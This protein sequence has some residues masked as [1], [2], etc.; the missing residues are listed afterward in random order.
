MCLLND[1]LEKVKKKQNN[2]TIYTLYNCPKDTKKP[3]NCAI[4]GN[5]ITYKSSYKSNTVL[6]EN[7]DSFLIC[8]KC[9]IKELKERHEK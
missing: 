5:E 1:L 7:G 6:A 3:F 2:K 4:C 9:A 8:G